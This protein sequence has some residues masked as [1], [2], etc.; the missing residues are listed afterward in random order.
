MHFQERLC[1]LLHRLNISDRYPMEKVGVVQHPAIDM[2]QW[3]ERD[4][5]IIFGIEFHVGAGVRDVRAKVRVRQ[6]HAFRL[7]RGSGSVNDGREL[8]GQDLRN[9]H[10]ISRDIC[11]AGSGDQCFIAQTIRWQ[12]GAAIREY[13]LF[14]FWKLSANGLKLVHLRR[15][16]CKNNLRAAVVEDV[17]DALRRFVKI[18]WNGDSAGAR[19]G[20]IGGMPFRTVG[21]KKSDPVPGLH[22]QLDKCGRKTSDAARNSRTKSTSTH[23]PR[24]TSARAHSAGSQSHSAIVREASRSSLDSLTLP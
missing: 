15:A 22:S 19:D 3:Q 20:K 8:A 9:A 23:R 14:Q 17:R 16:S 13:N 4:G 24:E 10:S 7:A 21:S 5:N 12:I 18:N 11:A 2:R 1:N 6:H